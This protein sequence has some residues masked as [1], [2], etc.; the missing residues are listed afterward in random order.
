[1]KIVYFIDH[2]RPDGTQF[3]LRQIVEG[4]AAR[5]HEQTV[6]CLN[7]SWDELLRQKLIATGAQV[8]IIGKLALAAGYGWWLI[9]KHLHKERFDV[10][11]TLLFASDVVGRTLAHAAHVPRIVTSIQTRDEFY[12]GWQRWLVR[13]T[14]RWADL[15][16]LNSIHVRDFA[17]CEEGAQ[18]E[19]LVLIPNSIHVKNYVQCVSKANVRVSLNLPNDRILL[20]SVG[21]LVHQ[22]GFDILL[23][24]LSLV[25]RQ[26]LLLLIAGVGADE[27]QL[28]ALVTDLDLQGRVQFLGYRRDVPLL[29]NCFDF[30]VHASRFE[31]MPIVILEAMAAGCPVIA[32][33]V[34]GTRELI[35]DGVHGWLVPPEEP[36]LFARAIDDALSNGP[37]AERRAK[38]AQQ[39]VAQGFETEMMI[40]AWERAFS[41]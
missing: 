22:K 32:T 13:R 27:A 39:R 7:D 23:R 10:A 9:L 29:M 30:Y 11:V 41:G 16:L 36:L 37:E 31:G 4:M 8:W 19:R 15:V 18:A 20:G 21:R 1:M 35:Q 14:M 40:S 12:A 33:A 6:I 24:A 3:V 17:I 38:M 28:R 2:L 5:G 34:D 26:D 25:S